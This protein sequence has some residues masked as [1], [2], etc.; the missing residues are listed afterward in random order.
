[1]KVGRINKMRKFLRFII[2][3]FIFY[4]QSS[5]FHLPSCFA[6]FKDTG[7]SARSA[8]MGGA[9]TAVSDDSGGILYNPAG[10]VQA[11]NYE[12]NFMYAKLFTGLDAVDLGLNYG[13]FIIP[14]KIMGTFGLNWANFIAADLYREDTVTITYARNLNELI[15]YYFK[16][17]LVPEI[18]FGINIKYLL[19]SYTLD[20]RT[21]ID[22]VFEHGNSKANV[23]IDL[24][25]WSR[26]FAEKYPD[27]S[28]GFMLKNINQ[29]DVGLK[30]KDT[31]PME[32]RF[33]LAYKLRRWSRISDVLTSIDLVYRNQQW[34]SNREKINIHLGMEAWMFNKILGFR[35]G[36]NYN[37]LSTG[38][39]VR[40][41]EKLRLNL[42]LDYA[43]LWPMMI[44]ETLG[45]HRVALTYKF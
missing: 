14:T 34:G 43:F 2:I 40:L 21:R 7:W 9:Y 10:I 41:P 44:R 25:I 23:G 16:K 38:F 19:H 27:F 13:A 1:M 39:S 35:L 37:E 17:K 8:G 20:K 32:I 22:P 12:L 24:G 11:E 15:K 28:T 45:T 3:T 4:L 33:A 5:M 29:P 30:T 42:K 26:P 31:V 36:G 18:S 6:A